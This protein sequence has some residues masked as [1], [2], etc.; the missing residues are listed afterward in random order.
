MTQCHQ[1]ILA[2]KRKNSEDKLR[3]SIVGS[4]NKYR[5]TLEKRNILEEKQ[6]SVNGLKENYPHIVEYIKKREWE[7]F[8]EP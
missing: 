6:L 8:T 3:F 5:A 2:L 1:S 4:W 7:F